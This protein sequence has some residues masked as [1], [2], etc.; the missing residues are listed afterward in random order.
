MGFADLFKGG[1]LG[2]AAGGEGEWYKDPNLLSIL[3]G[4]GAQAVMGS[5]QQTWQAGVGRMG[6]GIG[7]ANKYGMESRKREQDMMSMLAKAFGFTPK[8]TPGATSAKI[9][10]DGTYSLAGD[11]AT[12]EAGA[13]KMGD[14]SD[15][16]GEDKNRLME[17]MGGGL[18]S[19]Q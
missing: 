18:G 17:L 3:L 15:L 7:I 13:I 10:A 4:Q 16:S 11:L 2:A 9:N 14:V 19:F 8:G 6:A 1:G 5:H 12:D